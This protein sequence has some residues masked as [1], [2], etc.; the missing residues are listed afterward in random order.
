MDAVN[1]EE[2]AARQQLF[3]ALYQKVFPAVAKYVAKCGGS[4]EEAKDVFQDALVSY[5]EKSRSADMTVNSSEGSYIYGISR[6]LWIRRY[7][8]GNQTT[9]L[10]DSYAAHIA[11]ETT[12]P[13]AEDKLLNFLE[14]AGKRCMELLRAFYYDQLSMTRVAQLF[15]FSGTRSATVQKYKCIEKVRET[16]KQKALTYEDFLE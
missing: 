8:E 11:V 14:T 13:V 2:Q 1:L 12:L 10:D 6:Y 9:R 5:Y 3:T 15:G 16:V 7:K 4:F